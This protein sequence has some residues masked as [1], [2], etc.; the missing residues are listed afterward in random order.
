MKNATRISLL[1]VL[2]NLI[3]HAIPLGSPTPLIFNNPAI[4]ADPAGIGAATVEN[5]QAVPRGGDGH[6]LNTTFAKETSPVTI[7]IRT[8]TSIVTHTVSWPLPPT[9]GSSTP[10]TVTTT[11]MDPSTKNS[12]RLPWNLDEQ[13]PATV[14][15]VSILCVICSIMCISLVYVFINMMWTLSRHRIVR[16]YCCFWMGGPL[17]ED[18]LRGVELE[19]SAGVSWTEGSNLTT[20]HPEARAPEEWSGSWANMVV[21]GQVGESG[22]TGRAWSRGGTTRRGRNAVE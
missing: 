15:K 13:P 10:I 14:T 17:P 6:P 2:Y 4:W 19:E 12:L 8:V 21:V 9:P 16:R 18:V 22:S 3:A 7:T 20:P 11:A 1:C 5:G